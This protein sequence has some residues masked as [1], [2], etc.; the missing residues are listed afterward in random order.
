MKRTFSLCALACILVTTF[1]MPVSYAQKNKNF[2]HTLP[3]GPQ[4]EQIGKRIA[5]RSVGT[6]NKCVGD[7][8]KPHYVHYP[9]TCTW[10]GALEFAALTKDKTLQ[11]ELA[12]AYLP[13]EGKRK[14]MIPFP[15]HV[16]NAVFGIVPF[17]LYR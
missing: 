4:P 11:H 2:P 6:V 7:N 14:P 9:V 10:S 12:E 17:A 15:D 13:L 5:D 8:H 3:E 16:D 1:S